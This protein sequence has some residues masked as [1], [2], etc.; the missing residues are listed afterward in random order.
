MGRDMVRFNFP[1]GRKHLLCDL[2][3]LE[4]VRDLRKSLG[5]LNLVNK[6]QLP[7]LFEILTY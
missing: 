3:G 7:S 1:N 5:I 6:I 2:G 4:V